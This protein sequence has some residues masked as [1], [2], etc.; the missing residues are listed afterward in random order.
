MLKVIKT[1]Y[2]SKGFHS[3]ALS[4]VFAMETESTRYLGRWK[5]ENEHKTN[6][7]ADYANDDHC[8]VCSSFIPSYN[9]QDDYYMTYMIESVQDVSFKK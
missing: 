7:K 1:L 3:S 5:I 6:L 2:L 9:D 8:G 4:T